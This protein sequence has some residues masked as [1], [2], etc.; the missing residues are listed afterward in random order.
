[1]LASVVRVVEGARFALLVAVGT[2]HA[3]AAIAGY[4]EV[5]EL[6][7][8]NLA[9]VAKLAYS[10]RCGLHAE[11]GFWDGGVTELAIAAGAADAVVTLRHCAIGRVSEFAVVTRA[12]GAK[13]A[14][15]RCT[16]RSSCSAGRG[17]GVGWVRELAIGTVAMNAIANGCSGSSCSSRGCGS[18]V[19]EVLVLVVQCQGFDQVVKIFL[20]MDGLELQDPILGNMGNLG[21]HDHVFDGV[22]IGTH[23]GVQLVGLNKKCLKVGG[24]VDVDVINP[25]GVNLV[26]SKESGNLCVV[27][28]TIQERVLHA[29]NKE[30]LGNV[31][32][33]VRNSRS[34]GERALGW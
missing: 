30:F 23:D 18:A 6:A 7:A 5:G 15:G 10:S 28:E 8:A 11:C 3:D 19:K 12:L 31:E 24:G 33:H 2:I 16:G 26:L 13:V 1:V 25:S 29:V 21:T 32:C 17:C 27:K 14:V 20:G 4:T 34:H 9:V 22:L